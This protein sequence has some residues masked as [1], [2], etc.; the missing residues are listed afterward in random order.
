VK[1]DAEV[2]GSSTALQLTG[3]VTAHRLALALAAGRR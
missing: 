3:F 2:C 1:D